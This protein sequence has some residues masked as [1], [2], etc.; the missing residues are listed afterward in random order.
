M[1]L[2][3]FSQN[4]RSLLSKFREYPGPLFL[5]FHDATGDIKQVSHP[6]S[7]NPPIY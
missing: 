6:P 3:D 2:K 7:Y 4:I 5:T 1:P